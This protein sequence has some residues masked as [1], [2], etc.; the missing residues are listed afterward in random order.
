MR[1]LMHILMTGQNQQ[2]TPKERIALFGG[3]FDPVHHAHLRAA[4][5]ALE[6]CQ[7]NRVRFIP[8]A[9]SPLKVRG[10]I[11]ENKMRL[12]MLELALRDEPYFVVD[13]CE[14]ERG[15]V[16][17]TADTVRSIRARES[18]TELFWIIGADQLTQLDRWYAVEELCTMV[19]FLVLARPGHELS[20]PKLP[21]LKWIRLAAPL[22]HES[23][24]L[25]RERCLAGLAIDDLVPA[26]VEAF[27]QANELYS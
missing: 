2:A 11:A 23:S 26:A 15:G 3:S 19:T 21:G 5:I 6:Y 7:L 16:S 14:L 9:K 4:R 1:K 8:A 17:Y 25:V 22:M 27:I 10:P 13:P 24:S 20:V 12:S 18:A